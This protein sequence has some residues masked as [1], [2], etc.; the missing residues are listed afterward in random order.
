MT[1]LGLSL[2]LALLLLA[3]MGLKLLLGT[4]TNF[5]GQ[6]PSD[7]DILAMLSR[8]RFEVSLPTPNTDP[9]WI[10]GTRAGCRVLIASVSPQGWHRAAVERRA[11]GAQ[12]FYSS[13]AAL[14]RS[15][16]ILGPLLT[17]YLR[18]A[19]R[20]AGIAAPAVRVRAVILSGDCPADVIAPADLAAL[21]G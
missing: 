21:S 11:A 16:P 19:E 15:Q 14:H 20:Y 10:T 18:R 4:P 13:G 12:L 8:N 2:A 17:H 7:D 9:Q 1:R 3:S 5:A 6:D